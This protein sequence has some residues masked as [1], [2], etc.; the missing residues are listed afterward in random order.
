MRESCEKKGAPVFK[1]R[2][3]VY[4]GPFGDAAG[5][6][7]KSMADLVN[8]A[9]IHAGGNNKPFKDCAQWMPKVLAQAFL[10]I[11]EAQRESPFARPDYERL[12]LVF[13]HLED[14]YDT[15]EFRELFHPRRV[16]P[17]FCADALL[18]P[19]KHSQVAEENARKMLEHYEALENREKR[20]TGVGVQVEPDDYKTNYYTS[21]DETLLRE[22]H[23]RPPSYPPFSEQTPYNTYL[24][25]DVSDS[26]YT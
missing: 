9:G 11:Q 3:N 17:K 12:I 2:G 15:F 22:L 1:A 7:F 10:E 5:T 14:E 16:V 4:S 26:E 20:G 25:I 18:R 6:Q 8:D 13:Q 23:Q 21:R 19:G 24:V